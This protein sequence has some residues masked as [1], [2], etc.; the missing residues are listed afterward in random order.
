MG[1]QGDRRVY[2]VTGGFTGCPEFVRSTD[3][4]QLMTTKWVYRVTGGPGLQGDRW[5]G[6][7]G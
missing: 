5:A 1:L 4:Y 3:G 2:R 6:I 7:T